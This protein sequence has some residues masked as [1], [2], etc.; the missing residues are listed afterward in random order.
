MRIY[1]KNEAGEAVYIADCQLPIVV[2]NAIDSGR[3]AQYE[4]P[5]VLGP[6]RLIGN[7]SE[8]D[9]TA[10]V[11]VERILLEPYRLYRNGVLVE[12]GAMI[13]DPSH[14]R[15]LAENIQPRTTA[16]EEVNAITAAWLERE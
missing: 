3:D 2:G 14:V 5:T 9:Y 13:A 12:M 6:T 10:T 7:D 1:C 16:R 11:T 8:P 15:M 4:L